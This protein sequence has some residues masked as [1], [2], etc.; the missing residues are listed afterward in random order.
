MLLKMLSKDLKIKI[1][2]L[3]LFFD[4]ANPSSSLDGMKMREK[5]LKN[6]KLME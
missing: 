5:V 2:F 3:P 4:A 6:G 1:N